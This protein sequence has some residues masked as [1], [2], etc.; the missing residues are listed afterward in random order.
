MSIH[1]ILNKLSL[2]K[3][4]SKGEMFFLFSFR[5][6]VSFPLT[7]SEGH[8]ITQ[9]IRVV[10]CWNTIKP[11]PYTFTNSRPFGTTFSTP[12]S[13]Q[14]HPTT[15]SF[16]TLLL[17]KSFVFHL[18]MK[19]T[20]PLLFFFLLSLSLSSIF[21][22]ATKNLKIFSKYFQKCNLTL[23]NNFISKNWF[24]LKI[25]FIEPNIA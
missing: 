18:I 9:K 20:T 4:I 24:H 5:R 1:K 2:V 22:I 16:S 17:F 15:L 21:M 10:V 25:L 6:V 14:H 11:T 19:P 7:S 8:I 3:W 23:K 12:Q 13:T